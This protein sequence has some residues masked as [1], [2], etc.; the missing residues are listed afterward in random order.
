[1]RSSTSSSTTAGT[2]AS[3]GFSANTYV[4]LCMLQQPMQ[5]LDLARDLCQPC[6]QSL[7]CCEAWTCGF[8]FEL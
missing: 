5:Q 6:V 8:G 2:T 4:V 3:I 1:V 7:A